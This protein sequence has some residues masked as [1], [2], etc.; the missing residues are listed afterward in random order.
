MASLII[1]VTILLVCG[2]IYYSTVDTLKT[3]ALSAN[4]TATAETSD[5]F[6]DEIY[7]ALIGTDTRAESTGDEKGR[8]DK[9]AGG[10]ADV[11]MVVHISAGSD[12][13]QV[14]SIPRDLMTERPACAR[15][16]GSIIEASPRAQINSVLSTA[17]PGCLVDTLKISTGLPINHF[18]IADF[19]AVI[20]LSKKIGG[21]PVCVTA[22]VDDA[23]SG[24]KLPAGESKISGDQA[25]AFLR[26]RHGFGDGSDLARIK[27]QQSFV[28]S[29]LEK[30]RSEKT[31][32]SPTKSLSLVK[33]ALK[34]LTVDPGLKDIKTL[35]QF[36]ASINRV[37]PAKSQFT[38]LPIVADPI[39]PNRVALDPINARPVLEGMAKSAK[40]DRES[41]PPSKS[42]LAPRLIPSSSPQTHTGASVKSPQCQI[43][44]GL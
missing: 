20:E 29:A 7:M 30:I 44:F 39:D 21:V 27:A 3:S 42:P 8:A 38:M 35:L 28:L 2:F 34:Y 43:P 32:N 41:H 1:F 31:L 33:D 9:T 11:T 6:S 5:H 25:L 10:N 15:A 40:P 13:M 23:A 37:D 17:G 24:L 36:V 12:E 19:Q 14:L 26:T 22:P 18:M 16:D 4:P